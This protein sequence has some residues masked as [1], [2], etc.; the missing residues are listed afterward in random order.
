[1]KKS[2]PLITV[3]FIVL[4][5][6]S[7]IQKLNCMANTIR[8]KLQGFFLFF[9]H[10]GITFQLESLQ[11]LQPQPRIKK[12]FR[13]GVDYD[14]YCSLLIFFIHNSK[15]YFRSNRNY[16]SYL[17]SHQLPFTGIFLSFQISQNSMHFANFADSKFMIVMWGGG[18]D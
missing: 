13:V 16:K 15:G 6:G 12:G 1:M 9:F 8:Q 10:R 3:E 18:H 17:E 14:Y 7:Q 11:I 5:K 4:V 2:Y